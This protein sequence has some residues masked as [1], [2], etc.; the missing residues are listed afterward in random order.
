MVNNGMCPQ[1]RGMLLG[2]LF[3]DSLQL[4]SLPWIGSATLA[5][6]RPLA[7]ATYIQ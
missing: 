4:S 7:G 5:K 1:M 2:V 3:I 6:V